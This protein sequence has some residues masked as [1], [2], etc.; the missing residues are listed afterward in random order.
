MTRSLQVASCSRLLRRPGAGRRRLRRRRQRRRGE[1]GH[2]RQ[3]AA[4]GDVHGQEEDRVGQARPVAEDR[5]QGRRGRSG[6]ITRQGRRPVP[7]P[8]QGKLPKF[9]IDSPSRAPARTQGRAD[10]DRRQGLRQLP[11]HRATW[12]PTRSSSSSRPATSRRR[13]RAARTKNQ[14]SLATLGIDPR[15]WLTNAKNEG[16]AKV[17]DNDTIKITGGVDV[18]KLLD[19]VNTALE[20]A[21]TLGVQGRRTCRE[22]DGRAAQAGRRRGQGPEGRDLHRQGRQDPAPDGRHARHRRRPAAPTGSADRQ[23]RPLALRPQRGPGDLRAR[24]TP[25]RSTSCSASSAASASA[26]SARRRHGRLLRLRLRPA[27]AANNENLEKYSKCVT[28]AGSDTTKARKCAKL[29][30]G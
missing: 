4:Q 2:R 15:K 16:E 30:T 19:D 14:Q 1:L 11:G 25:S 8:G 24:P 7:D 18:D 5:R 6:P 28:D 23:A 10:L 3:Q 9:D 12:S 29:L 20:K 26:A 17:G 21:R 13:S 22:A 27:A